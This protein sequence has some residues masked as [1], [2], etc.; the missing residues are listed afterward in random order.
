MRTG[1][2]RQTYG[3]SGMAQSSITSALPWAKITAG[4]GLCALRPAPGMNQA[5][6]RPAA[7]SSHSRSMPATATVGGSGALCVLRGKTMYRWSGH[8]TTQ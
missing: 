7:V 5:S 3:R 6:T 2:P 1:T 8:S 4:P